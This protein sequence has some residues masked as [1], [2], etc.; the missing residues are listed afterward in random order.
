MAF[1]L[2]LAPVRIRAD[3]SAPSGFAE[4]KRYFASQPPAVPPL[5]R[6]IKGVV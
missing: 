1:S 4:A 2:I 6:G 3:S 5:L